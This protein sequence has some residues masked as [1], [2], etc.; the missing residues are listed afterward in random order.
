MTSARS[1]DAFPRRDFLVGSAAA[2]A[3]LAG[4]AEVVPRLPDLFRNASQTFP[5]FVY[6]GGAVKPYRIAL[7]NQDLFTTLPCYCGCGTY[8]PPHRNLRDCFL[9][10]DG[11]FASHAAGCATCQQEALDAQR[12]LAAGSSRTEV[13]RLLDAA[14]RD[15]GPATDTPA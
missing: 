2:L 7:N 11:S 13:R 4:G 14:Y 9:R 3:L 6:A 1:G 12:W 8:V 5:D 15:R 10:S